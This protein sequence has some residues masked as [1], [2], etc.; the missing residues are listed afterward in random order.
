MIE[1]TYST[2]FSEP[3]TLALGFFDCVH[4]GHRALIAET[5]RLAKENGSL[6][7]V[8][9]FRRDLTSFGTRKELAISY[10]D[11]LSI[12]DRL[13]VKVVIAA[14]FDEGFAKQSARGFLKK[15]DDSLMLEGLCCGADFRFGRHAAG[16][17][18]ILRKFADK[19]GLEFLELPLLER[20]GRKISSSEIRALLASGDFGKLTDLLGEPFFRTGKVVQG[21]HKGESALGIPTA[22]VDFGENL[23]ELGE[24]V[25][26]TRTF[27]AGAM[28][29]SVT[30]IGK[31]ETFS[32]V[33]KTVECHLIGFRGDLYG[34]EIR[35][36]FLKKLR[37]NRK[38][39]CFEELSA[40]IR[41]DIAGAWK[42]G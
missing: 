32:R 13:G 30:F 33:K 19:R 29:E 11:R 28:Y 40:Q 17:A 18:A 34:Q 27:A 38:F 1:L 25:F 31:S 39:E 7:A 22:N 12:F 36:F 3:L 6:S 8:F 35:I 16:D 21:F 42:N 2:S 26:K 24:G 37:D 14:D 10:R 15:L 9:T 20:D 23:S 5:V 4:C 41:S